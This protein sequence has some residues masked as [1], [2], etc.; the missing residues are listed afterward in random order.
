MR[1]AVAGAGLVWING[2]AGEQLQQAVR[3]AVAAAEARQGQGLAA[4]AQRAS[5][6]QAAASASAATQRQAAGK[7]SSGGRAAPK[8]NRRQ[9]RLVRIGDQSFYV[10]PKGTR[11]LQAVEQGAALATAAAAAAKRPAAAGAAGA[12]NS[13]AKRKPAAGGTGRGSTARGGVGRPT[14]ASSAVGRSVAQASAQSAVQRSLRNARM[15]NLATRAAKKRGLCPFYCRCVAQ[16]RGELLVGRGAHLPASRL[17]EFSASKHRCPRALGFCACFHS[18]ALAFTT[19]ACIP[20]L[21][22]PPTRPPTN[23]Q[24]WQVPAGAARAVQSGARPLQGVRLQ[25]VAGRRV[26][27][28]RLPTAAQ[29]GAGAHARVHI[30]PPGARQLPGGV[31]W[32]GRQ[33]PQCASMDMQICTQTLHCKA[34]CHSHSFLPPTAHVQGMCSN[35]SCPYLHVNVSPDAPVCQDFQRGHCPLGS[36]C[37]K[38][39]THGGGMAAAGNKASAS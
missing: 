32:L 9:M 2:S 28:H 11:S 20:L 36:R 14:S 39:H 17:Q 22:R 4:A 12:T 37:P 8:L 5:R 7:G 13:S 3:G 1:S 30:L 26:H 29:G 38:R 6:R 19:A 35:A 34:G 10:T 33:T 24:A 27:Q 23:A 15:R 16:C 25:P 31:R 18:V 21:S